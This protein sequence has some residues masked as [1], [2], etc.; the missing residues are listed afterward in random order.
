MDDS[1]EAMVLDWNLPDR[2]GLDVLRALRAAGRRISVL[3]LAAR[4]AIEDR[5][6]GLERGAADYLV[7]PFALAELVARL[8]SLIRRSR[9]TEEAPETL[10]VG[11][12]ALDRRRREATCGAARL[13]LT[14]RELGLLESLAQ[15]SGE[16]VSR[17]VLAREAL[18]VPASAAAVDNLLEVNI[19]RLRRKL[20]PASRALVIRTIR[21]RGFRLDCVE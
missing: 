12:L 15:R 6:L 17:E 20:A 8:R 7:K 16:C 11:P 18:R 5:V 3:L 4:E 2:P 13:A 19:S 14:P 21:G 1:L 10:Q 9:R